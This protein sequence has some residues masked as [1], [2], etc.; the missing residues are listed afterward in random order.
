M[1]LTE[2]SY[3]S[4]KFTP[5]GIIAILVVLIFYYIIK[6]IITLPTTPIEQGA[7]INPVF[8]KIKKPVIK[9]A[10]DS[11]G[12]TFTLDT[13][14]GKPID[15]PETAN[16]Y[17]LPPSNTKVGYRIG[18][19]NM[20]KILGI[21]VETAKRTVEAPFYT[22]TDDRQ[23]LAVNIATF[24]FNYQ[25]EIRPDDPFLKTAKIPSSTEII[26]KSTDFLRSMGRYPEELSKGKTNIIYLSYNVDTKELSITNSP[27]E[28][29]MVE[30]DFYRPDIDEHPIVSPKY[31]NSQ[32]YVLMMFYENTYKVI[33]A[34]VLFFEKSTE[35]V[36]KYPLKTG[37]EAF[38]ELK[39]GK[40]IVSQRPEGV[41]NLTI[42]EMI[43]GYFDPDEYQEYL[44]PVYV[45]LGDKDHPF[46]G[47]VPAVANSQMQ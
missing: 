1:T 47:F 30:V 29:N 31:F 16:V 4:R 35:Q 3:Y 15:A 32:N 18:S 40:A 25:Y 41:K 43:L 13:I 9:D 39:K 44:Q 42:K 37:Q 8:G 14:E 24:N 19:E 45:F 38:E 28:A 21:D 12:I 2:L 11:S 26:N 22:F 46:V 20:A 33:R 10:K 27:E 17:F 7:Q 6:I 34:Q 5:F 23:K 36:G